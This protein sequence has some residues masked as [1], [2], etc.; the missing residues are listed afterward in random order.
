MEIIKRNNEL[1][2]KDIFLKEN[3]KKLSFFFGGNG[4][5][6]W[7]IDNMFDIEKTYERFVPKFNSLIITKENFMLYFIFEQ[8]YLDIKN[9]NIFD[10]KEYDFPPYVETDEEKIE[11]IKH[12][13]ETK[14][15]YRRLNISNYNELFD[16][17]NKIITWYSD[18]VA[19]EVSNILKIKKMKDIFKVSFYTQPDIEGYDKEVNW[20]LGGITVRIRNS[21]SRY[22]PFNIPFMRMY[23]RLQELENIY[24]IGH[25]Y[26]IEEYLYSKQKV[27]KK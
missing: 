3:N 24:D 5:L 9:I 7:K 27:L 13:K 21:G 19:H 17:E 12:K 15:N 23:N 14:K 2:I 1:G 10:K 18:E 25:Q 16:E 22:S 20:L 4:D 8:L 26:H 11:Y 6:Y